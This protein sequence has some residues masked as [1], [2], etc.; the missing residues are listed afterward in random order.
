MSIHL[1]GSRS[2]PPSPLVGQV[3]RAVLAQGQAIH[4]GCASGADQQVVSS[5]IAAGGS[6]SLFVFAVGECVGAGSPFGFW[7]GSAFPAVL[8]AAQA[9]ARVFWGAGGPSFGPQA[10]PLKARLSRRSQA[11]L[12][13]CSAS[14]FFLASPA[15]PGSLSVA[16]HAVKAGQPVFAFACGFSG[17]PAPLRGQAGQWVAASFLGFSCWQWVP[18]AVQQSLF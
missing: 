17:P 4:V 12:A 7:S 8:A 14:V 3:V 9:G 15:S 2:L 5:A 11:A 13:G 1:G 6:S 18:A 16:A 10:L